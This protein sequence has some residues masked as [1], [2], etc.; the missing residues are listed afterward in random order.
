[1][2]DSLELDDELNRSN[3][4]IGTDDVEE[5]EEDNNDPPY[6]E[7]GAELS[8][9]EVGDEDV[10]ESA[11]STPSKS[12]S[13]KASGKK[14]KSIPS[15]K[16]VTK[17]KKRR[18]KAGDKY[19]ESMDD[20][21]LEA[22]LDESLYEEALMAAEVPASLAAKKKKKSVNDLTSEWGLTHNIEME[23]TESDYED[24]VDH[25]SYS[26]K[27]KPILTEDYPD[28]T[29]SQVTALLKA[30]WHDFKEKNPKLQ[31][32]K[33]KPTTSTNRSA[34]PVATEKKV[35][36]LK[37]RLSGPQFGVHPVPS[38]DESNDAPYVVGTSGDLDA[39][40][41]D[42]SK[43]DSKSPNDDAAAEPLK[44]AKTKTGLGQGKVRRKR[45]P[46]VVTG[47]NLGT[48]SAEGII[49]TGK[50]KKGSGEEAEY[51]T[52]HQDFCEE[53]HAGGDILLCDNCPKAYHLVCLDPPLEKPPEG[54]WLC[55]NC[56]KDID[57]GASGSTEPPA[58]EE[59]YISEE[60]EHQE[61]CK[62]C[63]QGGQL[64][65]CAMCPS[66]YHLG[67]LNPP[68]LEIP[69]GVWVCP[70]CSVGELKKKATKILFWR[71]VRPSEAELV[72]V[73]GRKT[74]NMKPWREFLC[75]WEYL[76]YWKCQWVTETQLEI[77]QPGMLRS[78]MKKMGDMEE[79]PPIEDGS[80]FGKKRGGKDSAHKVNAELEEKYYRYGIKPEWLQIHRVIN[81]WDPDRNKR[82]YLVKWRDLS[83][84][85]CSWEAENECQATDFDKFILQYWHN[86][87]VMMDIHYLKLEKK[88]L[89]IGD[90][91]KKKKKLRAESKVED[92]LA[93]KVDLR[94][95]YE[96]QP[97]YL[98]TTGGNLHEYQLEGLNWLRFSYSQGTDTILAD[99]MGLGKTIQTISFLYSLYKEGHSNG[100]FLVAAPLSTIINWER[101]FE[102][103]A[104]EFYVITYV[105]GKDA[106]AIIRDNEL[107]LDEDKV[108][109]QQLRIKEGSTLQFH[110]LLTS[111]ELISVDCTT[112][113]SIDW[114]VLV[115][116]EAHRLKNS[117]SKFFR[118]LDSYKIDYRLL[119]TGTP[120][121]NN[122]EEL[123]HLLN[124]L[125]RDK[126]G[127]IQEFLELFSDISK[128]E[129]VKKLHDLLASHMLRR[130]KQDVLKDLPSKSEFIVRVDL[131]P[132]QKKYYRHILTRNFEALN[133]KGGGANV[134]LLNIMM[135]LKKCANHPYLFNTAYEEAP[136]KP[137]GVPEGNALIKS[138]GKL[139]LLEKMLKH[140][141]ETGHR[142]LIFSQMTKVLDIL[143][144]FLEYLKYKYERV[145]GAITGQV[146][147]EA[148]DR[149][150][151]P[152]AEQFVFLLSTRAGGLG[153]NL[154]TADTVVIYDSDWNPHNDI[155]ALS[156]A[157]RIGQANKVMIYRFVT[158]NTVEERI[159]Q[160]AKKKMMLTHLVVRPGMHNKGAAGGGANMSKQ[161]LDDIL[162]FGTEDLFKDDD[163]SQDGN[164]EDAIVYDDET[165]R[166]LL[167]RSQE[168]IEEKNKLLDDYLSSFKVASYIVKEVQQEEE[169]EDEVDTEVIKQEEATPTTDPE[170]WEKLLRHHYE[171]EQ[172]NQTRALGK[173]KRVR[174][175]VNYY[176]DQIPIST[177][178]EEDVEWGQD[179]DDYDSDFSGEGH[180]GG[181]EG[182]N[183]FNT[184]DGVTG[185][186]RRKRNRDV[187][188]PLLAKVNGAIEV[189]GF[190]TRQRKSFYN[191]VLRWGMPPAEMGLHSTWMVRDL[192]GKSEKEFKA[193]SSMFLRHLCEPAAD[194]A[195]TYA[196]GVP[197][198]GV[199]RQPVLTRIGVMSLI[200]K[201]VF[202]FEHVNGRISMPDLM[203]NL[204]ELTYQNPPSAA[205]SGPQT[206]GKQ[207]KSNSNKSSRASTPLPTEKINPASASVSAAASSANV[208]SPA[209]AVKSEE[210][211]KSDKETASNE[212]SDKIEVEQVEISVKNEEVSKSGQK[213]EDAENTEAKEGKEENNEQKQKEKE[214]ELKQDEVQSKEKEKEEV[215][216]T[217]SSA[218]DSSGGEPVKP[219]ETAA[220][221]VEEK[222]EESKKPEEA[223]P[224]GKR[225]FMF[226][227]AD[228]G[229]TEL[230]TLWINEE[231][232]IKANPQKEAEIWHRRHDYWLLCGIEQYGYGRYQDIQQDI[233]YYIINEP[234][235]ADA[236]KANFMDIKNRF[237]SKRF[238]LLE[239][240]LVIEEQ[241][242]RAAY[243]QLTREENQ[244]H[245]SIQA[246]NARFSE[247]E[248]LADSH[249][250]LSK[251]SLSGNKSANAVLHKVLLQLDELLSDMRQDAMKLPQTLSKITPVTQRLQLSERS[252]LSRLLQYKPSTS[253]QA[254]D[255][256]NSSVEVLSADIQEIKP[257]KIEPPKSEDYLN[258]EGY[259]GPFF[260]P[261]GAVPYKP[262]PGASGSTS[263]IPSVTSGVPSVTK[264]NQ[265]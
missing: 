207:S 23:Y 21:L 22:H 103:W 102:F 157:H 100:P 205:S 127:S 110:V 15:S 145:D 131:A 87:D 149:F 29:P 96:K 85:E 64:L 32:K 70:R 226:N 240:A 200:R 8:G 197:R 75:K 113:Q 182:D 264:P 91:L 18:K 125:S 148:I 2:D 94:V 222:M 198:E 172:E 218:V 36:P 241:L 42:G 256:G 161:E 162:K 189:F 185:E 201:K 25:K 232:A 193:Y 220:K 150:N 11:A 196:D 124:F 117:Q 5:T 209:P 227:I 39:V 37:I 221:N 89:L 215:S 30:F 6:H 114:S 101:E 95:K 138:C 203:P 239:Q 7:E 128:E 76:S 206:P 99:E 156:R 259:E 136:K 54:A 237:I 183:E 1:M 63:R 17:P 249:Q 106:R 115:V 171:Q 166:N 24:C 243:L 236:G 57:R 119:L 224:A 248:S 253:A 4:N 228:G 261:I 167:D 74:G 210:C 155:Q 80:S 177:R 77:S 84:T 12:S 120:L 175:Q 263:N 73:E 137:N 60:D 90:K 107:T 168:G 188:P 212:S 28:L 134:S 208:D 160:V 126:F 202:E 52:N 27:I 250:H 154:A 49:R 204:E 97:D 186:R 169:E 67:C 246:L 164:K 152:N 121:Q 133:S 92:R 141:K 176:T 55:P 38:E 151:S 65:C 45:K 265:S 69:D 98:D 47:T 229:F 235:K 258:S 153:I 33:D 19:D 255:A 40:S 144:D 147:Q 118:V 257:Q 72:A 143:E 81:H 216:E 10:S 190:N 105:G 158:R 192:R 225:R 173:G 179:A 82:Y 13:G 244:A 213:K 31:A 217:S 123:Y 46:Q 219:T 51:D 41:L 199:Q 195:E 223:K 170:Y 112:L 3:S 50:W 180:E 139:V 71:W 140:L 231:R 35:K 86:R 130:L 83:H 181:E 109:K 174:K 16:R 252:I 58:V 251:E 245:N 187:L 48:T 230:H 247:L 194:N 108:N 79:P 26:N 262:T 163:A 135:E 211:G 9:A 20:A 14:R 66:T 61:Y 214:S 78:Y 165:V 59:A 116:D 159:T 132:M 242:R 93:K 184:G 178:P 53:C 44:K 43:V 122:L 146:R 260:A 254:S 34:S 68:L 129:Q 191:A 233:Q 62:A 88:G 238:K 142:V 234:F 56:P 111:Y 104:P